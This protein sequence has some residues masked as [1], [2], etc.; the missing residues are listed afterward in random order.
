MFDKMLDGI[1]WMRDI[2]S[3]DDYW[4]RLLDSG[5]SGGPSAEEAREDYRAI[6]QG[7]SLLAYW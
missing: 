7:K 5:V 6:E 2:F 1:N 3:F 4:G